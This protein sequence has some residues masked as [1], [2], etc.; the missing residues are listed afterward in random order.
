MGAFTPLR[1]FALAAAVVTALL[2]LG[3]LSPAAA[4]DADGTTGETPD[5]PVLPGPGILPPSYTDCLGSKISQ[6][7]LPWGDIDE[8]VEVANGGFNLG[9]AGWT[10]RGNT[11]AAQVVPTWRGL[12][13][14]AGKGVK[15]VSPPIC[16]D[17]TRPHA[18]MLTRLVGDEAEKGKVEVE[19][20]YR[21]LVGTGIEQLDVGSFGQEDASRTWAP[22]PRMGTPLGV[23]RKIVRPDANGHR[24]FRYEFRI[25]GQALWQFDDLFVDPR[26]RN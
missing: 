6:P 13:L 7:F 4:S 18:R 15:V 9:L 1:V 2:A 16:F 5:V 17:E 25:K 22:T 24:W 21:K 12:V 14:Q 19:V 8:Y 3:S 20:H 11:N 26:R 10:L 23:I